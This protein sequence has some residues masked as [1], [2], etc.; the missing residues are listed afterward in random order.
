MNIYI[1]QLMLGA[2]TRAFL[3]F[4]VGYNFN[5]AK[6]GVFCHY[7]CITT[8]PNFFLDFLPIFTCACSNQVRATFQPSATLNQKSLTIWI[9]ATITEWTESAEKRVL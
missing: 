6:T 2:Q 8:V 9:I 3:F 5:G 1:L 7:N 4:K